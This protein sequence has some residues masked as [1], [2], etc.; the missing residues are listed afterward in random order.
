MVFG[1]NFILNTKL[2]QNQNMFANGNGWTPQCK[3]IHSF[4]LDYSKRIN[5]I[6]AQIVP[7]LYISV[8]GRVPAWKATFSFSPQR[9]CLAHWVTPAFCV[10]LSLQLYHICIVFVICLYI[11]HR[12][13]GGLEYNPIWEIASFLFLSFTH[14]A[15]GDTPPLR[16]LWTVWF[17]LK[18]LSNG[19]VCSS[20]FRQE[21]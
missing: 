3:T 1:Q 9:C 6:K 19:R 10:S 20:S 7:H 12:L 16:P 15:L 14:I 18:Q 5:W 21:L 8:C 11:Y 4:I 17:S 13:L 2:K